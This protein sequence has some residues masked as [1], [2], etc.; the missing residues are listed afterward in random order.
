MLSNSIENFNINYY[1]YG[2]MEHEPQIEKI[3][4]LM[5]LGFSKSESICL[6]VLSESNTTSSHSIEEKTGLRQPEVSIS[7]KKLNTY[8]E[9][10]KT[11]QPGKGR[12]TYLFKLKRGLDI[13]IQDKF[14]DYELKVLTE[15]EHI[16]DLIKNPK[17]E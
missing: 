13:I 17:G 9:I 2:Y 12:P 14:K 4:L 10:S 16:R 5:L 1:K 8:V 3:E 7:M 15:L 11:S 6:S